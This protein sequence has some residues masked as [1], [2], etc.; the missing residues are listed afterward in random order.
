AVVA[1]AAY[2][3]GAKL[4]ALEDIRQLGVRNIIL[5]SV[6]P[7]ESQTAQANQRL[8]AY[9]LLRRDIRRIENSVTYLERVVT[10]KEVGGQV[11]NGL[12]TAPARVFGTEPA[13]MQAISLRLARGRYL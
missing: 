9:G 5:R 13:L 2:G 6:K 12:Y 1:I 10:L 4:A 11:F 8:I 3:E 7:P